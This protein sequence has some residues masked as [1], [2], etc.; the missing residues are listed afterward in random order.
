M[1]L[2]MELTGRTGL[3]M[4]NGRLAD[5]LDPLA[6]QLSAL[7]DKRG[8][9]TEEQREIADFEWTAA[10][11]FDPELGAYIPAENVIR[12]FRDAATAWKLGERV[13]DSVSVTTDKIPLQ[14]DG[15]KT[16]KALQKLD[17]FRFRKTVKIGRNRTA[18]TRP[19][20]RTWRLTFDVELDDT[21]LDLTD[22]E[23]IVERA[24]R[25]EGLGTAR[26]LGYGRFTAR[27]D[28]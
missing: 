20:F 4:H 12:S 1:Q 19:I 2:H 5:P 14:H 21:E 13:Y 17:A 27:V 28:I 8:R 22:F 11:Y 15:P 26:K 18:R 9:T 25:L 6:M 16:T 7:T 10:L 24:G 23:R 3:V